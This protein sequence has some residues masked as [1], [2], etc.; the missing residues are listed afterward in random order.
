[1]II[2]PDGSHIPNKGADTTGLYRQFARLAYGEQLTRYPELRSQFA[3]GGAFGTQTQARGGG[4]PP[5]LMHFDIGG[6]RGHWTQSR[7]S[8]MGPLSQIED[9]MQAG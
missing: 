5:D 2:R 9:T 4:G 8:V 1:V 3:W 7:P 6:E